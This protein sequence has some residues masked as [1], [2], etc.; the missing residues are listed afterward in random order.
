MLKLPEKLKIPVIVLTAIFLILFLINSNTLYQ[1]VSNRL[2]TYR[3]QIVYFLN[4]PDDAVFIPGKVTPGT[5]LASVTATATIAKT[6]IPSLGPTSKP[7]ATSTPLPKAKIIPNVVYVDQHNRWNYCGPANITMA[8]NYWGWKGTRDDVAKAIKPGENNLKLDFIQRGKSDK[9]VM[10]YEMVDFVN[11][12]TDLNAFQRSGGTIDLLKAYIANGLPVLI[13]KGY[14]ERDYT[15]KTTWMGHYLFVTGYDDSQGVFIVQDAYLKP[16]KD[17]QS[18]YDEFFEGWRSFNYLFMVIYPDDKTELVNSI[19]GDY[20]D[21]DFASKAA[22]E[23]ANQEIKSAT[24]MDEFFAWF[25]KGTSHVQLLEYNDAATAFDQAFQVYAG[26]K[27]ETIQR[28]YRMM[29]YQTAA[30]KAYYYTARHTDVIALADTTLN[31]TMDKPT[32]EESLFWRGMS[33]IAL[34]DRY[35]GVKDLQQAV[36]YNPNMTIAINQ[37]N[38]LKAPLVP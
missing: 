26:L 36:Y 10:P 38:E 21:A 13:E 3:T 18:K 11:N 29:W 17:L 28:P 15:G 24:G 22:L 20:L 12:E 16:G 25:N 6:A 14:Y 30:Y 1:K 37:L 27:E 33:E 5:S 2:D 32:L 31:E 19:T 34:G 4:P 8:L 35:G 7:T 23:R 9:N